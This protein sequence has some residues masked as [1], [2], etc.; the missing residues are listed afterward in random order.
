MD[1]DWSVEIGEGLPWID[2]PWDGWVDLRNCAAAAA[3]LRG[4]AEVQAY[5]ELCEV[6]LDIHANHKAVLSSKCDVFPIDAGAS[7]PAMMEQTCEGSDQEPV[8]SGLGSY[9]DL[10]FAVDETLSNFA[11]C[12]SL[13]RRVATELL[14][15]IPMPRTS[16]ELVIRQGSFFG[17]AGYGLTLYAMGFGRDPDS[18]RLAWAQVMSI[19][20]YLTMNEVTSRVAANLKQHPR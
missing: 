13:V 4:L 10:A 17:S 6:L 11:W 19:S 7:L 12:E 20:A 1:A 3:T 16:V 9:I 18:A 5:P 15:P 8:R 2:V 14:A